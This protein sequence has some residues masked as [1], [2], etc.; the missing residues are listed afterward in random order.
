[1]FEAFTYIK[2]DSCSY[3]WEHYCRIC[4][5]GVYFA[6]K[7]YRRGLDWS[8]HYFESFLRVEHF[9]GRAGFQRFHVFTRRRLIGQEVRLDDNPEHP[10]FSDFF[11]FFPAPAA[12]QDLTDGFLVFAIYGGISW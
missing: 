2:T 3:C 6:K 11:D 1:M 8:C 12:L 9:L 5:C 10:R 4:D 7:S